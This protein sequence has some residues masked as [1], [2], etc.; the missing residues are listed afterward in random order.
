MKQ[1]FD[2]TGMSCSACSAH[3]EK[4]VKAL[5]GI[6]ECNVN[7]LSNNMTVVYNEQELTEQDIVTAVSTLR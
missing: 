1:K 4:A 5:H 6:Q 3:V 2:V 7:L